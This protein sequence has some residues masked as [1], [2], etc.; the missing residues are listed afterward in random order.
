[1]P[2][3]DMRRL[4]QDDPEM[5]EL[6]VA[7]QDLDRKA[8]ETAERLRRA[9]SGS[10]D[11]LK[12]ELNE[13]VSEHFEARQKRRELQLKRMEEEIQRLRDAIKA[14]NDARE[15]IVNKRIQELTGDTNPLD[16]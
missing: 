9:T 6:L 16:F 7:D 2:A 10:R 4:E 3:H 14:R 1:M 11:K 8:L 15:D 12:A 13:I 5:H